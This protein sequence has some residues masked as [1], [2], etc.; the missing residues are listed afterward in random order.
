MRHSE[1]LCGSRKGKGRRLGTKVERRN[2]A[3]AG[4]ASRQVGKELG[5]AA[6]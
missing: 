4:G 6:A 1:I 5:K 2:Q 3:R